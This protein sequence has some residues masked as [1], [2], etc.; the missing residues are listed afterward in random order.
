MERIKKEN[1]EAYDWLMEHNDPSSWSR[2]TF[3]YKAKS[4]HITNNMTESFNHWVGSLRSKPILNLID[5]IR[6]KVMSRLH[7]IYEKVCTMEGMVT[8][9]V[10]KKLMMIMSDSRFCTLLQSGYEQFEVTDGLLR[11]VVH[12]TNKTCCCKVWDAIGI[13]C[14]H[15]ASAIRHIRGDMEAYCDSFYTVERYIL[16]HKEMIKPLLDLDKL[17]VDDG[18]D[19]WHLPP[20]KR[21]PSRPNKKKIEGNL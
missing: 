8:P 15:A 5:E 13:P 1:N 10:R 12:V 6:I 11:F 7:K 4:D 21:Q 17:E 18:T 9:N 2:H 20:L 19:V 16:A 3:D 14:K